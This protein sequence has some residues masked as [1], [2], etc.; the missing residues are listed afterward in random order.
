M[1]KRHICREQGIFN[2]HLGNRLGLCAEQKLYCK[3]SQTIGKPLQTIVH[4]CKPL[5]NHCKPLYNIVDLCKPLQT[6][7]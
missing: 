4:H 6:I 3:P 7:L 2:K 1:K 5:V